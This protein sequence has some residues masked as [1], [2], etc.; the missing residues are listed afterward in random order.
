MNDKKGSFPMAVF[1]SNFDTEALQDFTYDV[2]SIVAR[3]PDELVPIY[4]HSYGGELDALNGMLSLLDS[5]PNQT[6]TICLGTAMSAGLALLTHGD[7]RC[8]GKYARVMMHEA[9]GGV[10]GGGHIKDLNTDV[11]ETRRINDVFVDLMAKN[12]GR[13][14]KDI[15][16]MLA[17]RNRD[18]YMSAK[19]A[20][21]FGIADHVGIP[22]IERRNKVSFNVD[23]KSHQYPQREQKGAKKEKKA[24]NEK[25]KAKNPKKKAKK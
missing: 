1:V 14:K 21:K 17:G 15:K 16:E 4:I 8:I 5:I 13:P 18:V 24:P 9:S 20:V 19:E 23:I 11:E 7:V 10:D 25:K 22:T 2:M 3:G 6:M 12:C